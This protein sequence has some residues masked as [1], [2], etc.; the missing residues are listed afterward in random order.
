LQTLQ[1]RT[2]P[3]ILDKNTQ[4]KI[5]PLNNNKLAVQNGTKTAQN[6]L[7]ITNTQTTKS[8]GLCAME[9]G[10]FSENTSENVGRR[11]H[12]ASIEISGLFVFW[13]VYV[14]FFSYLCTDVCSF[15]WICNPQKD[16]HFVKRSLL[17]LLKSMVSNIKKSTIYKR[18]LINLQK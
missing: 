5:I 4:A 9:T 8:L 17:E 16:K 1:P 12:R 10:E 15:L 7:K 14:I 2:N 18:Y 3:R 6:N 11:R 13:L